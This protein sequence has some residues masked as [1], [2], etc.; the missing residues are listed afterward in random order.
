MNADTGAFQAL[1]AEVAQLAEQVRGLAQR[2]IAV[3]AIFQSGFQAGQDDV[4]AAGGPP[5]PHPR[6]RPGP[7]PRP[8]RLPPPDR[9][10][11]CAVNPLLL[12]LAFVSLLA[13]AQAKLNAVILGQPVSVPVLGII[14]LAVV[15]LLAVAVLY[16]LRSIA[17]D[18]GL[19]LRP[20]VVNT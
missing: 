19:R 15:L 3:E 4:P 8:A 5:G 7:L 1:T 6:S 18:L 10:R 16:L 13:S 9:Q 11:R 14:A 20:R 2:E 12:V 17:R